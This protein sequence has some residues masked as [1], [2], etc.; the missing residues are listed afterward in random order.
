MKKEKGKLEVLLSRPKEKLYE[1]EKYL[2]MILESSLDGITVVDELGSFEFGNDSFYKIIGWPREEII[3]QNFMKMIPEDAKESAMR[4]WQNV[5]SDHGGPHEIKIKTQ[6]GEIK[7]L[8]VSSSLTEI[9]GEMKV[10]AIVH[11]IS[12]KKTLE[13]KLRESMER[14]R[15][16]FEN[17]IVPMYV[18][19][20]EGYVL[21]MN[22]AGIQILGCTEEEVIGTN[23]FQWLTPESRKIGRVNQKKKL[24]GEPVDQPVTLEIINKHGE[25]RWVEIETS[26]LRGDGRIKEVHGIAKD[27][28][29]KKR[30]EEELRRSEARYRDLFENAI[31]PMYI[32]DTRGNI[33]KINKVGSRM[34]GC[35]EDEAINTNMSKW[36]TPASLEMVRERQEKLFSEKN[37][38]PA[39]VI[40][41]VS[42]NGEH[43]WAE[44]T[45][46]V[47]KDGDRMIE[48]H[49]IGRDITENIMLKQQ[50]KK[51]NKT[52]KLLC[53]LIEGTRGGKTRALIL[54]HLSERSYNAHQLAVILNIDYKTS[55]HHL[56]VLVKNGIIS[57]K[58]NGRSSAIYFLS[59]NVAESLYSFQDV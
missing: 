40:E 53:Y 26:D 47:I 36:L 51:S 25:Q 55:R 34:L 11:D 59:K 44:I 18:L 52:L 30:L 23:I 21:Q 2:K 35:A 20:A 50:I 13:I 4:H 10:V 48:I 17:A 32:L 15:D 16:L 49:G 45:S 31:V 1:L 28:T 24:S 5:Q 54:K 9:G 37:V 42:K 57:M 14:Y 6:H 27:I 8:H 19:D 58:R 43:R 33:F 39:A 7:Y 56:D 29:E 41:F 22:K 38:S 12:E 46:R 3:G